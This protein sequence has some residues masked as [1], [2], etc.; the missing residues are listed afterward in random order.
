MP[1][2]VR[3]LALAVLLQA[4]Q[5]VLMAVPANLQLGP[6]RTMGPRDQPLALHGVAGRLHR[7]LG[8]HFEGLIL[9]TA[10]VAVVVLGDASSPLTRGCATAYLIA[11]VIYVP[12][13]AIGV[14]PW[15]SIAW[16]VG[17]GVT[18]LMV[19]AALLRL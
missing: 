18:V 4:V 16:I 14:G 3:I 10:A 12:C 11:R 2:E 13:Y 1:Y 19:V 15:R 17:F 8:N 6:R 9:F 5:F 7:A